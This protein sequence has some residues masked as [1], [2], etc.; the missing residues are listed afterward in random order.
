MS[1]TQD[2]LV[3]VGTEELPPKALRSLMLAFAEGL[4]RNLLEQRLSFSDVHAYASPRRLAVIV[5]DLAASQEAR[6]I[7][8]KGPPVSVAFDA[9][10]KPTAAAEAFAGKCG[11][12][13]DEIGRS[14][15]DKGEWLTY[16]S[17][18]HGAPSAKLLPVCVNAALDALPIPRRMRWGDSSVE[19]VRPVHWIVM[20]HG[21]KIVP[22]EVL[23]V[24]A[25]N[26]T[27]GHRFMAAG[28]L[29]VKHPGAYLALL[30]REGFVIADFSARREKIE[31]D[32]AAAAAECGGTAVG[33]DALY[34][35]VT[36]LNEWPVAL[37]GRFDAAFLE[38]PREVIVATLTG[39]QRYFSIVGP[40][41][42]LVP[43]FVGVANLKSEDPGQ[44]QR[45]NERVIQPRLADA[46]FFWK[47]DR[48]HSLVDWQGSLR[49]VVYQK[50]L[51]SLFD[52]SA[53]VTELASA[54]AVAVGAD[55]LTVAR[56][57]ELAKCDLVSGMVG[58]FPEL[59]GIMG[60]YYARADGEPD[61]VSKAIAE[62]YLPTFAGDRLPDSVE[63][64]C[65]SIAD[66]LD[67]LCGVFALGKKPSGNRDPFGLRRSA[68]GLVRIIVEMRLELSLK[69]LISTS[70]ALQIPA[71]ADDTAEA[72]YDFVVERMRGYCRDRY[73][74]SAEVFAAVRERHPDSLL[75]FDQRVQ[76][77]ASFVTHDSA[78]SLAAANK[79]IANILRKAE[80]V[81]TSTLDSSLLA[82]GAEQALHDAL[83]D[84]RRD[85]DPLLQEGRYADALSRLAGLREIV[86]GYFDGVMVM[87][88]DEALRNNRLVLLADLRALFLKIADISR[89]SM[90]KDSSLE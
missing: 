87:V 57:A 61:A 82:A 28:P 86:D 24:T 21:K 79:R 80:Y 84:A 81:H 15:S 88:E 75:D 59:Q 7:T 62:Q 69:T 25:G 73:N 5:T 49:D 43:A 35:E 47:A 90:S 46:A 27:Q 58:E 17:V 13:I 42:A 66:K 37:T 18:E 67:S 70:L 68:L 55:A 38:L 36:A 60:G 23:G 26:Q 8:R 76:A 6:E 40:D 2:F 85:L 39:H 1:E 83:C 48:Q 56:A 78:A 45:G 12:T 74:T 31:A 41:G 89:L 54:A 11:V 52:K 20:L 51:G 3:E 22:G 34:E 29:T 32:V 33:A 65:L 50:G 19:F 63:S 72:V 10:G 53:R 64:A 77:V 16:V 9:D 14:S 4:Q 44:V 30:E 71:A